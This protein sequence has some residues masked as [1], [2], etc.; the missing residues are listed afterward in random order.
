MNTQPTPNNPTAQESFFVSPFDTGAYAAKFAQQTPFGTL[1]YFYHLMQPHLV[2]Y[3]QTY[4]GY[5]LD[6]IFQRW[7][8]NGQFFQGGSY[9]YFE[10]EWAAAC[11]LPENL[12]YI[13]AK[14][15]KL[16]GTPEGVELQQWSIVNRRPLVWADGDDSGM[17][18]DPVVD[19]LATPAGKSFVTA[20]MVQTFKALWMPKVG[21]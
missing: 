10:V 8:G 13:V 21:H 17:L 5:T 19:Q 15:D 20:Q 18:I 11:W 6:K 1:E 12:L 3:G 2:L 7:Y 9:F 14:F 4:P 16:W